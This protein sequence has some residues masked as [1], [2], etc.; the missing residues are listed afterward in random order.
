MLKART[1]SSVNPKPDN[2]AENYI[3]RGCGNAATNNLARDWNL[4]WDEARLFERSDK[5]F[6]LFDRKGARRHTP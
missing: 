3:A 1:C 5:F 2:S 4:L 6:V